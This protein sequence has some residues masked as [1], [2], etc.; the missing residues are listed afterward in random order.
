MHPIRA[1]AGNNPDGGAV[2]FGRPE[3]GLP[4]ADIRF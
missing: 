4:P 2:V 3:F 1:H